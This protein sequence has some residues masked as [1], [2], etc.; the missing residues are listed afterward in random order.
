MQRIAT[1][2]GQPA[3]PLFH[4]FSSPWGEHGVTVPFRRT[5]DVPA[6]PARAFD[7]GGDARDAL[8]E[9]L[10]EPAMG[11]VALD[12]VVA[13]Q[14]QSISLNVSSSGNLSCSYCYAAP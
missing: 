13:P 4:R 3:P 6:D 7:C 9:T 1:T 2:A 8:V 10:A 5:F 11:E 12:Q 14:P